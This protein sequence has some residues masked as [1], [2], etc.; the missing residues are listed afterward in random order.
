MLIVGFAAEGLQRYVEKVM[1]IG[2]LLL[3]D[4]GDIGNN[5]PLPSLSSRL[6]AGAIVIGGA[7]EYVA[8]TVWF[9]TTQHRMIVTTTTV[10][11]FVTTRKTKRPASCEVGRLSQSAEL[12]GRI[13][14]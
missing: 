1:K 8:H 10:M 7:R 13:A 14:A 12:T 4:E 2:V 11:H 3:H 6:C 9:G 5:W